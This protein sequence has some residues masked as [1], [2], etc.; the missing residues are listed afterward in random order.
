MSQ[1]PSSWE[2]PVSSSRAG[3]SCNSV[4][5]ESPS[6]I[7]T[8]LSWSDPDPE[9]RTT[10]TDRLKDQTYK[11]TRT[12]HFSDRKR[13]RYSQKTADFHRKPQKTA[14]TRGKPQIGDCPL[15]FV[16]LSE[17]MIRAHI[18]RIPS[19]ELLRN[20]L[21]RVAKHGFQRTILASV[22]F[23]GCSPPPPKPP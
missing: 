14:G 17:K 19:C 7:L 15:R 11:K 4:G 6:I 5:T 10:P 9:R 20:S 8:N 21:Q 22:Y 3:P 23:S 18:P 12:L 1:A 2:T 16:P 13:S